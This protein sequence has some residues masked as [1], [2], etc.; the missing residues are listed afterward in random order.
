MKRTHQ[1][2]LLSGFPIQRQFLFYTLA[3]SVA[4]CLALRGTAEENHLELN[5]DIVPT[6]TIVA[7]IPVGAGPQFVTINS[8]DTSV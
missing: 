3:A 4:G 5:S 2:I 7:T 8:Q 6:N 1:G